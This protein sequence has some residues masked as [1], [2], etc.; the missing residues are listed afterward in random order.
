MT[1]RLEQTQH[2]GAGDGF[3][4]VL[5]LEFAEDIVI[6]SFDRAQGEEKPRADLGIR[7]SLGN[8]LE[9]FQLALA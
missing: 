7:A 2:A 3:G 1:E 4:T 6:V 8:K 9:Y 5:Y